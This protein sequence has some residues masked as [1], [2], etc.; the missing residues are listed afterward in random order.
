MVAAVGMDGSEDTKIEI[1]TE[2]VA[3]CVVC[4]C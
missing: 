1:A 4:Y 3:G 2:D